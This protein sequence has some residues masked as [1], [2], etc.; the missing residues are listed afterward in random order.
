MYVYV[1]IQM[2]IYIFICIY[3]IPWE[4]PLVI[5]EPDIQVCLYMY[6]CVCMFKYVSKCIHIFY[7]YICI[8]NSLGISISYS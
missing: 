5:A 3:D 7:K 4:F 8:L 6:I 1:C 2:Y